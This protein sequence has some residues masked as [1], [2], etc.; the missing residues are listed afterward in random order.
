[1]DGVRPDPA[2]SN[3]IEVQGDAASRT[4]T[5]NVGAN[6]MMLN[7]KQT[8]VSGNYTWT[9]N[10][11]NTTGAFGLPANGDDIS[12]RVGRSSR[13][14]IVPAAIVSMSPIRTSA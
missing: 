2:F 10:E 1:M 14:G 5:V 8:F 13:R 11:S 9:S 4:H 3:V 7:W 12:P 6:L